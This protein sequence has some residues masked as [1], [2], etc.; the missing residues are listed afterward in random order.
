M[1]NNGASQSD[2]DGDPSRVSNAERAYRALKALILSNQLPAGSQLLEQE[3]A[4]RLGMSRTP[5]REAMVRLEQDGVA[6]IRPRHGMRVLPVSADDMREIYEVLTSLESTAAELVARRGVSTAELAQLQQA[7]SDMDA[8]LA[9]DDLETW[10]T[11]DQRFHSLLVELTRNQRLQQIVTQL[12]EQ[13]HRAR[14]LTLRLRPKPVG[15]NRDHAMLVAA[16]AARDAESAQKIHHDHR[17]KA[18]AML[19]ELLEKLGFTQI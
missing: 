10:A 7:V 4:L 9:I 13:A 5:I 11:A 18:G 15:S 8:A 17:A 14:M 3:A 16:I 1:P 19:V 2:L 12:G 6:E